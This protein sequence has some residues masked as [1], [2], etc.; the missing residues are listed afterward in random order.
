MKDGD[1]AL[2]FL[3][4]GRNVLGRGCEMPGVKCRVFVI[5]VL[6]VGFGGRHPPD[7][8]SSSLADAGGGAQGVWGIGS[9]DLGPIEKYLCTF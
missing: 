9:T 5:P 1:V 4:K 8:F 7:A 6:P 3:P 2:S